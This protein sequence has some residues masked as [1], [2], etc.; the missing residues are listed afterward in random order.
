MQKLNICCD[1][2]TYHNKQR[3][4]YFARKYNKIN[5]KHATKKTMPVSTF[6]DDQYTITTSFN[7]Q[8]IYI[9]IINTISYMCYEGNFDDASFKTPFKIDQI[10]QFV[11]K[12]FD[13]DD[14]YYVR[15]QLDNGTMLLQ[16]EG[17][18]GGFLTV[19]FELRL[20]EKQMSNDAQLTINFQRVEQKQLESVERID[21]AIATMELRFA[22]KM[23]VIERR[24]EALGHADICFYTSDSDQIKSAFPIDSKTLAISV[25]NTI[26]E[27]SLKKIK[28]FYQLEELHRPKRKMR[29]TFC[30]K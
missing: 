30:K 3:I 15:M 10:H 21:K 20:R 25:S 19:E 5:S 26:D 27:N 2:Q 18:V 1:I 8:S 22:Q 28:H 14:G 23:A 7:D 17:M 11:N 6:R 12:C 24:L 29:Q 16:F 4:V 9:K 13:E